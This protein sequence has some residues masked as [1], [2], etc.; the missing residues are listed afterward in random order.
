MTIEMEEIFNEIQERGAQLLQQFAEM[1]EDQMAELLP[2]LIA[3]RDTQEHTLAMFAVLK[4]QG[5]KNLNLR[6]TTEKSK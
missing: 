5:E 3:L 2:D 6:D 4:A 1:Q